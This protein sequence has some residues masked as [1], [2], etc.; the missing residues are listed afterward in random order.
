MKEE[1][2][3][4]SEKVSEFAHASKMNNNIEPEEIIVDDDA[5]MPRPE[6]KQYEQR[7]KLTDKFITLFSET[8]GNM[9][10]ATTLSNSAG[11]KIKLIDLVRFVEAKKDSMNINELNTI[12]GFLANIEFKYAR[13]L[14]EL[15]ETQE[16]QAELWVPAQ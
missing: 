8:V 10:Y 3:I 6:T 2:N 15:I 14:M 9:K 16:G 11:N 7:V 4:K 12:I 1:K 13:S 5:D